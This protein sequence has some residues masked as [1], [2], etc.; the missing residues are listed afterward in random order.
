MSIMANPVYKAISQGSIA[1]VYETRKQYNWIAIPID[2]IIKRSNE[3]VETS[4]ELS[5]K[6]GRYDIVE[7]LVGELKYQ[8]YPEWKKSMEIISSSF[9]WTS[10]NFKKVLP[11]LVPESPEMEV[12]RDLSNQIPVIKLIEYLIDPSND[13]PYQWLEFVLNSIMASSICRSDKVVALELIGVAFI[14]KPR[15]VVW[16]GVQCWEQAMALRYSTAGHN[17]TIPVV[18]DFKNYADL[19]LIVDRKTE[20]T[21]PTSLQRFKEE[22]THG[23]RLISAQTHAIAVSQ[24]VFN[25][26]TPPIGP[27]SFHLE[28]LMQ[29]ANQRYNEEKMYTCSSNISL[30]ILKQTENFDSTSSPNCIRVFVHT[31]DLLINCLKKQQLTGMQQ[32]LSFFNVLVVVKFGLAI[33]Q[34]VML[35]SP[36]NGATVYRCQ[37]HVMKKLHNLIL[38]N[39]QCSREE[40]QQLKECLSSYFHTNNQN[41]FTSLLHLALTGTEEIKKNPD[42]IVPMIHLFLEAGADPTAIDTYGKTPFHIL[43]RSEGTRLNSSHSG[44]SRMPSSA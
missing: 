17:L 36:T 44:G 38:E 32:Q 21:S 39:L 10:L 30:L 13:E 22:W 8:I 20:I 1:R 3:Q 37:F 2:F 40:M 33:L 24:R 35:L 15:N 7:F 4:L 27:N 29:Y 34:N 9:T 23:Y 19:G 6:N 42:K 28:N 12:I 31:L 14:F 25:Q 11:V 41:R 16:R 18:S 43:A 5:V 26:S